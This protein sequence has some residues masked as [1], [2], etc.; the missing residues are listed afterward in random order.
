MAPGTKNEEKPSSRRRR[1]SKALK[2]P[3]REKMYAELERRP[4]GLAEL[5]EKFNES[6]PW[7]EYH[8]RVL[9]AAVGI[10]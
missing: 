10:P 1:R 6:V 3:M 9:E 8:Y 7:V 5:A 4:M 2:H